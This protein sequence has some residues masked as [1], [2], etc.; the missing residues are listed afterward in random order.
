MSAFR[1]AVPPRWRWTT[2]RN[3]EEYSLDVRL[4]LM[5]VAPP[6]PG[7][8]DEARLDELWP[9]WRQTIYTTTLIQVTHQLTDESPAQLLGRL[10]HGATRMLDEL[11]KVSI[12][13][14]DAGADP[15]IIEKASRIDEQFMHKSSSRE[16]I[17]WHQD[18]LVTCIAR[19]VVDK[20]EPQIERPDRGAT[21]LTER[22]PIL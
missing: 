10:R 6:P 20:L 11:I 21:G 19:A 2:R 8:Q 18:R 15:Q 17:K 16:V 4:D 9:D 22:S 1:A 3:Y 12:A 5:L 14:V 7:G 13:A